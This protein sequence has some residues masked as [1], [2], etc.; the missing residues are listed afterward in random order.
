MFQKPLN[1]ILFVLSNGRY[2]NW[3]I[4]FIYGTWFALSGLAAVGKTYNNC[5]SMQKGV[6]FLLEIQN[7]DGGWGE[8]YLSCPEQVIFMSQHD[9]G[10]P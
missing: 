10:R 8:S 6:D 9:Q 7:E 1:K 5:L 2:G 4:C 3:G